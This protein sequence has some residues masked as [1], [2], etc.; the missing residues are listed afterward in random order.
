MSEIIEIPMT[1]LDKAC[2]VIYLKMKTYLFNELNMQKVT[3]V[4]IKLCHEINKA[5]PLLG[6][7]KRDTVVRLMLLLIEDFGDDFVKEH[8]TEEMIIDI[9]EMIYSN[10]YHRKVNTKGGCIII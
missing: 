4:I 6:K 8:V 5:G 7:T 2:N 3:I 9:I 10:G 1:K